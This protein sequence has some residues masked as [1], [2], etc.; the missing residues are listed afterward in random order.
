MPV[1]F[2]Y[3]DLGNVLLDF[4][5]ERGF[6][7]IASSANVDVDLV[8]ALIVDQELGNRY[9]RGELSTAQ[10]HAT[11][12]ESTGAVISREALSE[13]WGAIFEIKPRTVA[14]AA[15]LVSSGNR[16]GILSNTCEIHWEW[17]VKRFPTLN[18]LFNPVVTSYDAGVMKPAAEIYR[19][20]TDRAEAPP[21]E[22]V[23]VDDLPAN[24]QAAREAGWHAIQFTS[25]F[26]LANSL[27]AA[28]VAFNR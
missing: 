14:V 3:F 20:A 12:C 21:G 5:H 10:F 1:S 24:V 6:S 8:R 15:R 22:I 13:A 4:S 25:A 19:Q 7:Q 28:G 9:E 27:E 2:I 26:E 23:F 16:I 18:L 11:F 17:A